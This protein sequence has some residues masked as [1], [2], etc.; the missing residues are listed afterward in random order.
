MPRVDID[1][2]DCIEYLI[3]DSPEIKT[4]IF[5]VLQGG[6]AC[7]LRQL[8]NPSFVIFH[9]QRLRNI[10]T[11]LR[12]LDVNKTL[13]SPRD[14]DEFDHM[15]TVKSILYRPLYIY[16]ESGNRSEVLAL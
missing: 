4:E 7:R 3:R 9:V 14:L 10:L 6:D 2:E 13:T 11:T 8:T 12:K 16:G 5:R 1:A 15:V